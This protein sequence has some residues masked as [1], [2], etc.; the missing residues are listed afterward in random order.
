VSLVHAGGVW[1]GTERIN[2]DMINVLGRGLLG[3]E[4]PDRGRE[5]TKGSVTAERQRITFC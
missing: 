2:I 1:K 4:G 3:L 5:M